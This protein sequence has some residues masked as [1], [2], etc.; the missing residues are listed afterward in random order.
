MAEG[1]SL[2]PTALDTTTELPEPLGTEAQNLAGKLHGPF[3]KALSLAVRALEAKVGITNSADATSVEYKLNN[4]GAN[5]MWLGQPHASQFIAWGTA[6][7]MRLIPFYNNGRMTVGKGR[8]QIQT[9]AGN[10]AVAVYNNTGTRLA[11]T[12]GIACPSA[13]M[14]DV[15]FIAST[16]LTPGRHFIGLSADTTTFNVHGLIST[17]VPGFAIQAASH[18]CPASI[19]PSSSTQTGNCPSIILVP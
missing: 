2:F 8:F 14:Q 12:G 1:S 5:T 6:N 19:T 4:L 17:L 15:S 10:I 7:Q 9:A 16:T 18:P 13:G 3:H 11:T